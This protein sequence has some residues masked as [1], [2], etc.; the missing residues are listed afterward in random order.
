MKE[1]FASY[2]ART[3][4]RFR[5]PGVQVQVLMRVPKCTETMWSARAG[6]A[7]STA[8]EASWSFAVAQKLLATS[9]GFMLPTFTGI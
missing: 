8:G 5:V 6:M 2:I 9:W 7:A 3:S 1:L 4:L